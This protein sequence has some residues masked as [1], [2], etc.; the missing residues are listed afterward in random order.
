MNGNNL[1]LTQRT[2]PPRDTQSSTRLELV[3]IK[4]LHGTDCFRCIHKPGSHLVLIVAPCPDCV[5]LLCCRPCLCKSS[6]KT[7]KAPLQ[8]TP[9]TTR[10]LLMVPAS[11]TLHSIHPP[12]VL[13]RCTPPVSWAAPLLCKAAPSVSC[14]QQM[15]TL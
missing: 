9:I 3:Q 10:Q 11:P 5:L 13:G 4:T 12:T 8:Q 1:K 6:R 7:L 15:L 14:L 2:P